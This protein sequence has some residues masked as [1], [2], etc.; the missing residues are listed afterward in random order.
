M[1]GYGRWP[2]VYVDG[3]YCLR[4][5]VGIVVYGQRP[6]SVINICN[7]LV[8]LYIIQD[9]TVTKLYMTEFEKKSWPI[10]LPFFLAEL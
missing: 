10:L 5:T 8:H 1:F 9:A 7:H 4:E 6:P 3:S 2:Q